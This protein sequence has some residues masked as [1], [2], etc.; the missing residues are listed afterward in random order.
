VDAP[1][2]T[3][4]DLSRERGIVLT[5]AAVQLVNILEFMMIV[6]LGPDFAKALDFPATSIGLV[7]GS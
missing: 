4:E 3:P 6:P 5:V 7:S 1:R 2:A